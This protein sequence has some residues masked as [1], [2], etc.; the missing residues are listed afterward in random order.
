LIRPIRILVEILVVLALATACQSTRAGAEGGGGVFVTSPVLGSPQQAVQPALAPLPLRIDGRWFVDP[1]GRVAV[2]RGVSLA[3]SSKVPPFRAVS[4]ISDLD[5][6]PGVGINVV[7]LVFVWEAYEPI[8]CCYN[9]AYLA[10]LQAIA[11]GAAARGMYVIV[12]FHED[13]FSRF[14]SRGG[15][16]GFPGWA[17]SPRGRSSRPN[18]RDRALYWPLLMA[19]D[20]TTYKSFADFY[21]DANG[22]RTRYLA[23]VERVAAGFAPIPGVLGYDLLNE[24]WGNERNELAPLYCDAAAVIQSRH[25]SA[26]IFVEGQFTTNV[27]FQTRLPRLAI[28]NLVYAPHYYKPATILVGHWFGSERSMDRAFAHMTAVSEAWNVPLFVGE[29]GMRVEVN[30]IGPYMNALYDHL[31][32]QLISG[33][34]WNYTPNW[35]EENKDGWNGENYNIL[36]RNG[37]L[38]PNFTLRPYPRFTAGV[39]LRFAYRECNSPQC[40]RILQYDWVHA[41]ERGETEIFLPASLFPPGTSIAMTPAE[42]SWVYEPARQ[43]LVCRSTCAATVSLRLCGPPVA[44]FPPKTHTKW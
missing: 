34:Q 10:D 3:G 5:P 37:T 6:L 4:A 28:T 11:W 1:M 20:P 19:T 2:L 44:E 21:S 33:A 24:P 18:N 43:V 29:F 12:D 38:R 32:A 25:P 15:G 42:A 31:D 27:G 14:T 35:T 40:G 30:N 7:R 26:F 13:G 8:P 16:D 36:D 41:P 23:M 39:P 17:V 9:E 22:V